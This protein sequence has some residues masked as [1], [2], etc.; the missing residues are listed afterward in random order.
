MRRKTSHEIQV[1]Y[2]DDL[3]LVKV[4]AKLIIQVIV[5][6]VDNAIKYTKDGSQILI[7]AKKLDGFVHVSVADDGDGV[8]DEIKPRIFEMFYTGNT[9][10]ADSR[11]SLGLGLFLCQS[12]VAAHGG[13]I[14]VS[15]NEPH[16]AVFTFTIPSSEVIQHE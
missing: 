9:S 7:T 2:E 5:N 10:L 3:L 15:D 14:C 1:K 6:L 11:R 4:D 16:G 13:T 12:I 8:P